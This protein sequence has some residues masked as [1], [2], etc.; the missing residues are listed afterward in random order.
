MVRK[1]VWAAGLIC[2][3]VTLGS[4]T[5]KAQFGQMTGN[6]KAEDGKP[7][8]GAVIGIDREDIKGHYEVKTDKNGKFFHA[9]LPLGKFSVSV[10]RDGKKFFTIGGIQ[11]RLS[12]PATVEIDLQQE[13]M[14]TEAQASGV[15]VGNQPANQ[16]LSQE[17]MA[18]IEKAAKDREEAVKKRQ[19]LTGKFDG[20][21]NAMK[22]AK[23]AAD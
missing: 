5:A 4:Q 6:V 15:N 8:A 1:A 22:A 20:A 19:E 23:T 11:T 14:R 12:E 13:K 7:L 10:M 17:Q 16:K 2:L 9:G 21:M 3:L 18:T